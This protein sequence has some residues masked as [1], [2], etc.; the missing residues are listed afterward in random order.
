MEEGEKG[1]ERI[2]WTRGWGRGNHNVGEA[3][4]TMG[5]RR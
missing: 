4:G 1:G 5:G 3:V 2:A